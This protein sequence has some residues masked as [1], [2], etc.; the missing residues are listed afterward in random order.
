MRPVDDRQR[1]VTPPGHLAEHFEPADGP[2]AGL[3]PIHSLRNA[4]Q[5]R[6]WPVWKS[7]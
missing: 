7:H 5:V 3:D 6:Y 1:P 2:D 4:L